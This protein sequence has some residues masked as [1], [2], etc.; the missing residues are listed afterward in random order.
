[1]LTYIKKKPYLRTLQFRPF[2]LTDAYIVQ[3]N[4]TI[5]RNIYINGRLL[6]DLIKKLEKWPLSF[7]LFIKKNFNA[8]Y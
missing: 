7:K 6:Y 4:D 2:A 3:I 5:I 1:M 8:V